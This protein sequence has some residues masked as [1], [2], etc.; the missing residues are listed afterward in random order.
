MAIRE[1]SPLGHYAT[2]R[3]AAIASP[4]GV[5]GSPAR[6]SLPAR[7]GPADPAAH[8]PRAPLRPG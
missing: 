3:P 8:F 7:S 6:P 5:S 1:A 4:L 2:L